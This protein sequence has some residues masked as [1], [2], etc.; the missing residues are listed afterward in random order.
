[1]CAH[2]WARCRRASVVAIVGSEQGCVVVV[3]GHVA[4]EDGDEVRVEAE[5]VRCGHVIIA[6]NVS[7][8]NL[9]GNSNRPIT[10]FAF[11]PRACQ[12][13]QASRVASRSCHLP[14]MEVP[15]VR[16]PSS[17]PLR[18]LSLRSRP[19]LSFLS[20]LRSFLQSSSS[21]KYRLTCQ[22]YP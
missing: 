8:A 17:G 11:S 2:A 21:I 7:L 18:A 1:M 19:H 4:V 9:W 13:T 20:T 10:C 15:P 5:G 3:V 14:R 22:T 12:P 16:M 6:A